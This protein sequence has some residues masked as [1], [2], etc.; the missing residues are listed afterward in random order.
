MKP[1]KKRK[2]L[3]PLDPEQIKELDEERKK[4]DEK[5][6]PKFGT[7][8]KAIGEAIEDFL[9]KITGGKRK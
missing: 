3:I 1:S 6:K 2:Y 8:S 7:R 4:K 5:G 9:T